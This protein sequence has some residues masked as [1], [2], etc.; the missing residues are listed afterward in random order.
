MWAGADARCSG[1]RS[2]SLANSFFQRRG[3]S[4]ST[5]P[6]GG[7]VLADTAAAHQSGSR[8]R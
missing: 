4:S 2:G 7:G 3:V 1:E 6:R 8:G 5:H